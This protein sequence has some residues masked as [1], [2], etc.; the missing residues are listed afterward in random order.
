MGIFNFLSNSG[1]KKK[2]ASSLA[3]WEVDSNLKLCS[4]Q[5]TSLSLTIDE[6]VI[7]PISMFVEVSPEKGWIIIDR[8]VPEGG[9]KFIENSQS[10]KVSYTLN[11]IGYEFDSTFMGRVKKDGYDALK[12]SYPENIRTTQKRKYFRVA[13]SVTQPVVISI[14]ATGNE[15]LDIKRLMRD[16][17]EGGI[18]FPVNAS[19][20]FLLQLKQEKRLDV[21]HFTLPGQEPIKT[22]GIIRGIFKTEGGISVCGVEF[23]DL[24]EADMAKI[25]RYVVERQK[26]EL[27]KINS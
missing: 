19:E 17:S 25:Y 22:K 9:N 13:P 15:P 1:T 10:L 27:K 11:D 21:I 20:D 14:K 26:E 2:R 5:N 4:Q 24:K 18:S 6:H 7:E 3:R 12:I 23:I 16:I 8:L